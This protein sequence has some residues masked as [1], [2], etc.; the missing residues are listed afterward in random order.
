ML[1]RLFLALNP[2]PEVREQLALAQT[3]L[4]MALEKTLDAQ[5][6][7]RWT[8]PAQF[9]LT[10]LFLGNVL[11]DQ[12]PTLTRAIQE[13]TVPVRAPFSLRLDRY[14][15]FPAVSRPRVFWIGIQASPPLNE[16][17][18]RLAAGLS[19]RFALDARDY[20]YPHVTLARSRIERSL[21]H[22]QDFLR[23]LGLPEGFDAAWEAQRLS[24]MRSTLGA[25]G[26]EYESVQ[27]FTL[28]V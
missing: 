21:P 20:A 25:K 19:P 28:G 15:C 1:L 26:S 12:L 23:R 10:L 24:L 8:R 16:L 2:S 5:V 22:L 14:G 7:L 9:H 13:A 6:T 17:Q 4:R 11:D 27:E 18:H 3:H